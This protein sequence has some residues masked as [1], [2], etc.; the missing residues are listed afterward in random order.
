MISLSL[1]FQEGRKESHP[2]LGGSLSEIF[3]A[4]NIKAEHK[5]IENAK[6][7]IG[8]FRPRFFRA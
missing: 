6:S 4:S 7:E 3:L 2:T 1:R 5:G 8:F